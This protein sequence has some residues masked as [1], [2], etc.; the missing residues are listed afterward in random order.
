MTICFWGQVRAL[1]FCP[2]PFSPKLPGA[3][4]FIQV[5]VALAKAGALGLILVL[6]AGGG[7]LSAAGYLS[8]PYWTDES[9]ERS[10]FGYYDRYSA[11][12]LKLV[13]LGQ[14]FAVD[15]I[16]VR[17][18]FNYRDL[19]GRR[20]LSRRDFE[21][22]EIKPLFILGQWRV[23]IEPHKMATVD[24]RSEILAGGRRYYSQTF[25][26]LYPFSLGK[27]KPIGQVSE[28]DWPY[29]TFENQKGPFFAPQV[30]VPLSLRVLAPR[31]NSTNKILAFDQG[32][33]LTAHVDGA[34]YFSLSL[35]KDDHLLNA[36]PTASK[37]IV[38]LAETELSSLTLSFG[39]RRKQTPKSHRG[40]AVAI[41]ALGPG[42][43]LGW[44]LVGRKR[45]D[46]YHV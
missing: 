16:K 32:R 14:P 10:P 25:F 35:P 15:S 22:F 33:V 36:G 28:V 30:E 23:L 4:D 19:R 12:T 20:D 46:G 27:S 39:V 5:L 21:I 34:G 3:V 26:P 41:L 1:D 45:D 44:A 9:P 17:A 11:K 37:E 38:L 42:L 18:I 13:F 6:G 29:M 7:P 2:R 43:A 24:V 31:L 8:A 40:W